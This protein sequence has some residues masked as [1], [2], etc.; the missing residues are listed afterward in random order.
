MLH[1]DRVTSILDARGG[2]VEVALRVDNPGADTTELQATIFLRVDGIPLEP[3]RA[4]RVPPI[5]GEGQVT[6][7]MTY[8]LQGVTS[9]EDGARA[10]RRGPQPPRVRAAH[11]GRRDRRHVR[12][13]GRSC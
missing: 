2:P 1:V 7:V 13:A 11:G 5:P 6:A 8:E 12:A 10:G 9:V 4:S 3:T